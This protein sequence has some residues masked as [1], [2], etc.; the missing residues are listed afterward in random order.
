M[1]EKVKRISTQIIDAIL[2]PSL[3][4]SIPSPEM[5]P[6]STTAA[7]AAMPASL[8]EL[9]R[10]IEDVVVVAATATA[11][12]NKQG[13]GIPTTATATT[14]SSSEPLVHTTESFIESA[15][16]GS[17]C[18]KELGRNIPLAYAIQRSSFILDSSLT[19]LGKKFPVLKKDEMGDKFSVLHFR[20]NC[21]MSL[22]V[23]CYR[24]YSHCHLCLDTLPHFTFQL[25]KKMDFC[26][27]YIQL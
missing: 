26:D 14:P 2:C 12:S 10:Q 17:M 6:T 25:L 5:P 20:K 16:N 13:V 9:V 18:E 4:R 27:G 23:S 24:R 1:I 3:R 8:L 22:K 21:R 11:A 19:K 7:D 15:W